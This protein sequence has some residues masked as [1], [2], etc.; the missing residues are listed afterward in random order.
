LGLAARQ[1]APAEFGERIVIE[2]TL[3][4]YSERLPGFQKSP[5]VL[6]F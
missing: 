2:K 1:W 3:A 6:R 4:V 5:D